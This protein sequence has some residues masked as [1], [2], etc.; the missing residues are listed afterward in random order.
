MAYTSHPQQLSVPTRLF[1]SSKYMHHA[2]LNTGCISPQY[3]ISSAIAKNESKPRTNPIPVQ[4]EN[5][6]RTLSINN[7]VYNAN[8]IRQ[9]IPINRHTYSLRKVESQ[10]ILAFHSSPLRAFEISSIDFNSPVETLANNLPHQLTRRT[11]NGIPFLNNLENL[12][13]SPLIPIYKSVPQ[14]YHE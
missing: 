6:V 14:Q 1:Q 4:L 5:E 7:S 2:I 3:N 13:S 8:K 11:V 12:N 9:I 10:F